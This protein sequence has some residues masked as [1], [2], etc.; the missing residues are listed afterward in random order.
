MLLVAGSLLSFLQT[1]KPLSFGIM[2]SSRI[3]CGLNEATLLSVSCPSTATAVS[4]VEAGQI[5]FEQLDV[6]L[7]VVGDEN[8]AFFGDRF[9]SNFNRRTQR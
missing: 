7:V 8:A 1:S 9:H 6:R 4:H 2:M 5:R 3:R